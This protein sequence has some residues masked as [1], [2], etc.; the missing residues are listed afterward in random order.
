MEDVFVWLFWVAIIVGSIISSASKAKKK[1]EEAARKA[2]AA[3][4]AAE[5]RSATG[6]VA[7]GQ[8][9]GGVSRTGAGAGME[10]NA[11]P[12]GGTFAN[13]LEELSRQLG[14]QPSPPVVTRP[15]SKPVVQPAASPASSAPRPM[16]VSQPAATSHDYYSL[17]EDW[18]V[19]SSAEEFDAEQQYVGGEMRVFG[20]GISDEYDDEIA[21]YE[22]LVAERAR[23]SALTAPEAAVADDPT[24]DNNGGSANLRDILGGDFDLRRAVIEAEILTPKYV[25]Q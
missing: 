9:R 11:K 4:R 24:A 20:S 19:G 12:A 3:K 10:R 16:V 21:V 6:Q 7:S 8:G 5:V 17:E 25:S 2:A 14:E 18:N 13:V 15:L 22:N 1:Q 23:R